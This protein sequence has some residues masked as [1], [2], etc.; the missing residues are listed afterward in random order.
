MT[1]VTTITVAQ[2][3]TKFFRDFNFYSQ[4]DPPT[5]PP[6]LDA[7]L[8]DDIANAFLDA[9]SQFNISLFGNDASVTIAYLLLSAHCLVVNL[10]SSD[11]GP[12]GTGA[13]PM[14]ARSAG[15]VSESYQ[16]PDTYK[17]NPNLAIYT[18]T[19]YGIRYLALMLPNL[20]GN[21]VSVIGGAN[22]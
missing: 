7:V 21:V 9:Q 10:K 20:V 18:S 19:S 13:F 15:G 16:I 12:D 3:K 14:S 1:D 5:S 22:P 11:A 17:D 2:F 6:I 4:P 8:D